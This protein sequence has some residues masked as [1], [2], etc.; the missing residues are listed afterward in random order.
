VS[1]WTLYALFT[2]R[3]HFALSGRR[4]KLISFAA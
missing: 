2:D 1:I 3:T 4:V